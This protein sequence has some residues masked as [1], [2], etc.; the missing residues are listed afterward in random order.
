MEKKK[1]KK[2]RKKNLKKVKNIVR[3]V[4][5]QKKIYQKTRGDV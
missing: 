2:K 5:F 4:G 1:E 3:N